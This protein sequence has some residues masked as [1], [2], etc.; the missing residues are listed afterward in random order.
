MAGMKSTSLLSLLL[1]G[2]FI[3]PL[4]LAQQFVLPTIPKRIEPQPEPQ[5]TPQPA[6]KPKEQPKPSEIIETSPHPRQTWTNVPDSLFYSDALYTPYD[7]AIY[8]ALKNNQQEAIYTKLSV[9]STRVTSIGD[10][11][12]YDVIGGWM[13]NARNKRTRLSEADKPLMGLASFAPLPEGSRVRY[14]DGKLEVAAP[15]QSLIAIDKQLK[16]KSYHISEIFN[17]IHFPGAAPRTDAPL[18]LFVHLGEKSTRMLQPDGMKNRAGKNYAKSVSALIASASLNPDI[19]VII[20]VDPELEGRRVRQAFKYLKLKKPIYG[21]ATGTSQEP[22]EENYTMPLKEVPGELAVFVLP[23]GLKL[24][25]YNLECHKYLPHHDS[26]NDKFSDAS[27]MHNMMLAYLDNIR[28]YQKQYCTTE[29]AFAPDGTPLAKPEPQQATPAP[30]AEPTPAA[31]PIAP[32]KKKN[33]GRGFK[34][35]KNK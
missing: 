34:A 33:S 27:R 24:P 35:V 23:N 13:E 14:K 18:Y 8:E 19:E 26:R 16:C 3:Q 20:T 7:I 30:A 17:Q 12:P 1:L 31:E 4:A 32:K 11:F 10:S 9:T 25:L 2:I 21:T 29:G 6:Q 5:P 22:E 15:E 28:T